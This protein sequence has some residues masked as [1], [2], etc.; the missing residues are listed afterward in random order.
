MKRVTL[1]LC[2]VIL[3]SL[4]VYADEEF[5]LGNGQVKEFNKNSIKVVKIVDTRKVSIIVNNGELIIRKGIDHKYV[6]DDGTFFYLDVALHNYLEPSRSLANFVYVDGVEGEKISTDTSLSGPLKDNFEHVILES[7]ES[8]I[9]NGVSVGFVRIRGTAAYFMI[10]GVELVLEK[11]GVYDTGVLYF[12]LDGLMDNTLDSKYDRVDLLVNLKAVEEGKPLE[13][14]RVSEIK[15]APK[16]TPVKKEPKVEEE[17]LIPEKLPEPE[18]VKEENENEE[19]KEE[20]FFSK[21][22]GWILFWK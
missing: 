11:K 15:S 10:N 6:F 18:E 9:L 2:F 22:F 3:L 8:K 19:N 16:L 5:S 1:I 13:V 14:Q 21:W 7:G 12:T 17:E 4:V 20:G